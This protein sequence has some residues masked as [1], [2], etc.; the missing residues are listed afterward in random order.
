[1][2]GDSRKVGLM[3]TIQPTGH[4]QRNKDKVQTRGKSLALR[5]GAWDHEGASVREGST[6]ATAV[7]GRS[8][9]ESNRVRE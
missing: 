1:M 8:G 9:T 3:R 7:L 4:K 2:R 5:D 6:A